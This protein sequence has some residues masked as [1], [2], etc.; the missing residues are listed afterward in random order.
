MSA[1]FDLQRDF[2]DARRSVA[3]GLRG[4]AATSHPDATRTALDVLASGGNAVD[5][6]IAACAVLGVV[7]P[8]ATG[9]GGDC[10][11]LVA[12]R[13]SDQVVAFN[14]SGRTP[15][16]LDLSRLPPGTGAVLPRTSPHG[17]TIPGGVDAWSQ[18][19]EK[20]GTRSLGDVLQPAIRFAADGYAVTPRVAED[21]GLQADV[22]RA[23]PGAAMHLL[24]T[25]GEPPRAGTRHAQ[26]AL[27]HT[28]ERIARDGRDGF[29]TGE[30]ARDLVER[31]RA[32]GGVHTEADFAEARGE[33][34]TP[35]A[36]DYRGWRVHECPPNGQGLAA[37]L[38]LRLLEGFAP[39]DSPIAADRLHLE[40][41]CARLAYGVRDVFVGDPAHRPV[42][43][44][45]LLSDG[46]VADLRARIRPERAMDALP[47]F[48]GPAHT[49]T[50]YLCVVD[51]ERNAVSL[52]H[53]IFTPFGSGIVGPRSG[54]LLHNR[55]QSFSLD[56]AHPNA[57]A[58]RKRPMHTIIPAMLT[59]DGRAVMPFGVMGGHYQAMGQAVFLSRMLDFGCNPQRAM[60]LP[61]AFV[62]PGT[63]IVEAEA[64]WPAATLDVLRDRGFEI[65]AP[66]WA[67]GGSQAIWIDHDAG[68]LIGGS[69]PRKDG[70]ALGW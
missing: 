15:A 69:D 38:M 23:D 33:F 32:A 22:L 51:A 56:P 44:D 4:M 20:H 24:R 67:I 36:A 48:T 47:A 34:V 6:A 35:I 8:A 21:W 28:L 49:D 62:R 5:A 27:A 16:A 64:T 26:P 53:S 60:D 10:F 18:L 63:R 57:L 31:L 58:P 7:E 41:E 25:G 46:F 66:P 2:A 30:V 40:L 42:P 9:V 43:V 61:R 37:L 70:C 39:G 55:G 50:V 45:H 13:G 59:R 1:P 12:P 3:V 52:I 54:V 19:L 17:V 68:T 11:A 14:G 29:Y 65:V